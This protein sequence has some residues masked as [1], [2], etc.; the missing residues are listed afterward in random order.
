MEAGGQR[1]AQWQGEDAIT[2]PRLCAPPER[3]LQQRAAALP[4]SAAHRE[5]SHG[6]AR[7]VDAMLSVMLSAMLSVMISSISPTAKP[8]AV[9]PA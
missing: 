6:V 3:A 9:R 2:V 4:A 1:G 8:R 5:G 7:T